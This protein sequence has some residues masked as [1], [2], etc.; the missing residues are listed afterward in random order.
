MQRQELLRQL[1]KEIEFLKGGVEDVSRRLREFK[2]EEKQKIPKWARTNDVVQCDTKRGKWY[3]ILGKDNQ[4]FFL[5]D[6]KGDKRHPEE[7]S[8]WEVCYSD[9]PPEEY[10]KPNGL[11]VGEYYISIDDGWTEYRYRVGLLDGSLSIY[12]IAQRIYKA[13]NAI[14]HDGV[15]RPK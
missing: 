3:R 8:H 13:L 6:E 2:G 1:D 9:N 15:V 11:P 10:L 12:D 14:P 7:Y 4:G 5:K